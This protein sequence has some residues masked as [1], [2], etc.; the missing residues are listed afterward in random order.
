MQN[1]LQNAY[2]PAL[3]NVG[4][5]ASNSVGAPSETRIWNLFTCITNE[6]GELL[7]KNSRKLMSCCAC[8][9]EEHYA[10]EKAIKHLEDCQEAN[11]QAEPEIPAFGNEEDA[12]CMD[13]DR[14]EL[15]C[16]LSRH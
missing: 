14:D 11:Q 6:S 10:L 13:V 9:A 3:S 12:V 7:Q 15:Y 5:S 4:G 1:S 2:E 16:R 8:G